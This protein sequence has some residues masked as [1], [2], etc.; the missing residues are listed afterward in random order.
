MGWRVHQTPSFAGLLLGGVSLA[1]FERNDDAW[2]A[3]AASEQ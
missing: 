3:W 1:S 2:F